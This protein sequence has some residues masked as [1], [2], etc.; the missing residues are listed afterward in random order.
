M[1]FSSPSDS[2]GIVEQTRAIMRV[3]STQYPTSNIVNSCNTWSDKIMGYG[4]TADKRFPVDDSN[5]TKLPVG[6]TNL[7]ADQREYSFLTDEQG[8]RIITLTRI[9]VKDSNGNW[10]QLMP[11][12]QAQ[13]SP[14]ALDEFM[15]TSGTPLYYD[16]VS[17]NVIKLYP[18]SNASVTSG[19]K[20][21]FLR[22]PSYFVATDTT[23]E[24][25]FATTLHRGYVI[26]S[27]YDGALALGLPNLQ[28]LSV[29]LQKEEQKIIEYFASRNNDE[30]VVLRGRSNQ[31]K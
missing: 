11:I 31:N 2:L 20:F 17:D 29:E 25:G 21:Y 19:L 16:K 27:A 10:R 30:T 3:D 1:K 28:P 8:N 7:V 22:S 14:M 24:P 15:K 4:I 5:H 12:D 6:T 23:K 13:I 26:A 9:D 18:A